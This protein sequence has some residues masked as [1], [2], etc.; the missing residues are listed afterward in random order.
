[1]HSRALSV[2]LSFRT[3]LPFDRLPVWKELR[4][5]PLAEQR[6]RL[7]DPAL[8]RRLVDA[9]RERDERRAIGAEPRPAAYE[10]IFLFDRVDG[11]PSW[12]SI[13]RRS[14]RRCPRSCTICPRA[15][16]ASSSG[17]AASPRPS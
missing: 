6:Q 4:A 2:V 17:R 14:A 1:V 8:R 11:P 3:S 7:R 5:L 13:P 16:D 12:S 9:A 15:L 10:W